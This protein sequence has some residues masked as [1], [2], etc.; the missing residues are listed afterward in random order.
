M[1]IVYILKHIILSYIASLSATHKKL[2]QHLTWL[3]M[4][5]LMNSMIILNWSI[6]YR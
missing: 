3:S 1:L 6:K 2:F 5:F 4:N